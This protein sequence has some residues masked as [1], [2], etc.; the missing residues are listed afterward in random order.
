MPVPM[1]QST[2]SVIRSAFV[3]IADVFVQHSADLLDPT[4]PDEARLLRACGSVGDEYAAAQVG[5]AGRRICALASEGDNGVHV[6]LGRLLRPYAKRPHLDRQ[7]YGDN[8]W[9]EVDSVV[10]AVVSCH[11]EAGRMGVVLSCTMNHY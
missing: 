11:K 2:D 7:F 1:N 5:A 4:H 10:G 3:E 8:G 6:K 9:D